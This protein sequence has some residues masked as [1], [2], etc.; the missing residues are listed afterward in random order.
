MEDEIILLPLV[1]VATFT[2]VRAKAAVIMKIKK[3]DK[4]DNIDAQ[5]SVVAKKI[6][7]EPT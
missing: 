4:V 3:G 7:L 6:T 1:R 5:I 2:L